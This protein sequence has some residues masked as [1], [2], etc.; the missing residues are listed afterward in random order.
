MMPAYLSG[1]GKIVRL[2]GDSI[3]MVRINIFYLALILGISFA[4]LQSSAYAIVNVEQAIIGHPQEGN[5]SKLEL[6]A[7]GAS[8]NTD[9]SMVQSNLLST[10][11]HGAHTEF[12]Q[13]QY[14]YGQSAD[15]P[16]PIARSCMCATARRSAMF[17]ASRNFS[18]SAGIHL[19]G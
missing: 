18:R 4:S 1:T 8:G 15:K 6:L 16:I 13:M 3:T 17:G 2:I 12:L 7:S 19:R 14:A 11:Q 9:K 5:N 10:W